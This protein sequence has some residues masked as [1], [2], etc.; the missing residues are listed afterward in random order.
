[1]GMLFA[2]QS[3]LFHICTFCISDALQILA[4]QTQHN[5]VFESEAC[6]NGNIHAPK[7]LLTNMYRP[8]T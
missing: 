3:Q 4:P 5:Q 1:M 2:L 8:V 7:Y 6:Q